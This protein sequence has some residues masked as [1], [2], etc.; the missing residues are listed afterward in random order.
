MNSKGEVE[1]KQ[2]T[3]P[4]SQQFPGNNKR[5]ASDSLLD[6][7]DSV[8]TGSTAYEQLF[9]ALPMEVTT[10][11]QLTPECAKLFSK[12]RFVS[13]MSSIFFDREVEKWVRQQ[14]EEHTKEG[15][16]DAQYLAQAPRV[17]MSLAFGSF[18]WALMECLASL[19]MVDR[20][21]EAIEIAI[22]GGIPKEEAS[23]F[24]TAS[25]IANVVREFADDKGI[26][27]AIGSREVLLLD[28]G[29]DCDALDLNVDSKTSSTILG[30]ESDFQKYKR[31]LLSPQLRLKDTC[32]QLNGTVQMFDRVAELWPSDLGVMLAQQLHCRVREVLE[33][34]SDAEPENSK[35]RVT[36]PGEA[37]KVEP[38]SAE[39]SSAGDFLKSD[40]NSGQGRQVDNEFE[41]ALYQE[42]LEMDMIF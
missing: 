14:A 15:P 1:M 22:L 5:K 25:A 6:I 24:V 40:S 17:V 42:F 7:S 21:S 2:A 18:Y 13:A 9:E 27:D 29:E 33:Y 36:S 19:S 28:D 3:G 31:T 12:L 20:R 30:I 39:T 38:T 10:R 26:I 32:L 41:D 35:N 8:Q 34:P 37:A 16:G 4:D 23:E 11:R